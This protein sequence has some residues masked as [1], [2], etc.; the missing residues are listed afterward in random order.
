MD[1]I[2]MKEEKFEEFDMDSSDV[3]REGRLERRIRI[4]VIIVGIIFFTALISFVCYDAYK[5]YKGVSDG[6]DFEHHFAL[7]KAC[8]TIREGRVVDKIINNGHLVLVVE[9]KCEY[10]DETYTGTK[11]FTVSENVYN[12]YRIGDWF[13]SRDLTAQSVSEEK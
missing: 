13:D 1:I 4:T 10:N 12:S 6:T 9:N 5:S 2:D 3:E 7:E 8:E 11:D